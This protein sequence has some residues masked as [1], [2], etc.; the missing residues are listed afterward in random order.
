MVSNGSSN[1][2]VTD[3]VEFKGIPTGEKWEVRD[4]RSG[5]K[6]WIKDETRKL[7]HNWKIGFGLS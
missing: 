7:R 6:Y 2:D 3:Q 1:V 5:R 4:G